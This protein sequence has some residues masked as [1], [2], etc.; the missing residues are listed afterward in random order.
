[1]AAWAAGGAHRAPGSGPDL[2]ASCPRFGGSAMC[3]GRV[4]PRRRRS[5]FNV[6]GFPAQGPC[7]CTHASAR[8]ASCV[9]RSERVRSAMTPDVTIVVLTYWARWH[10]PGPDLQACR[11]SAVVACGPCTF[12]MAAVSGFTRGRG[13]SLLSL[14][15]IGPTCT[16]VPSRPMGVGLTRFQSTLSSSALRGSSLLSLRRISPMCTSVPSRP[17]GV[18][19]TRFQSTLSPSASNTSPELVDAATTLS[20]SPT[21]N[22][23]A[24]VSKWSSELVNVT[25]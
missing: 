20:S 6:P 25:Y 9:A 15:R 16:S 12:G 19:L 14:R 5:S 7:T 8:A 24:E 4:R 22:A 18:G 23:A 13:S 3:T 17:L 10:P 1:V 11:P 21:I 2:P